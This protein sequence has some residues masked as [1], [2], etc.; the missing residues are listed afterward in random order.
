MSAWRIPNR[1]G[2]HV[3]DKNIPPRRVATVYGPNQLYRARLIA[4]APDLLEALEK[5]AQGMTTERDDG[6]DIQVWMDEE[7]MMGIARFA[8]AKAKGEDNG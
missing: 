2:G 8:I 7:E 1:S 6:V 5:I 3:Y 4:A